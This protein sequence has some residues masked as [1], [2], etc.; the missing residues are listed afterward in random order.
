MDVHY[1]RLSDSPAARNRWL[2]A[3]STMMKGRYSREIRTPT[4][5]R[6]LGDNRTT[7]WTSGVP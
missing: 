3:V 5:D 2:S 6:Y 1:P 4:P 7:I